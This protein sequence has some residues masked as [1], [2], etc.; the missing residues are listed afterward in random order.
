MT[1]TDRRRGRN[2][3]RLLR[4][5]DWRFLLSDPQPAKSICFADGLLAEAVTLISGNVVESHHSPPGDCDLAV[6][7]NPDPARLRAAWAALHPGGV[8]YSEWYSP[9]AGG[10]EGVRRRLEAAGFTDI[11]CYFPWPW[12]DRKSP[13]FWLPIEAP[14]AVHC[15]LTTRPRAPSMMLRAWSA[16]LQTLWHLGLRARLILPI[17]VTARKPGAVEAD[18]NLP[19]TIRAG[20][21]AWGLGLTPQRLSWLLLTGGQSN[22]NKVVSLVFADSDPQPRMIVKQA[23]VP[24]SIPALAR[25]AATLQVVQALRPGG[26]PGVPRVIFFRERAGQTMLGETVLKGQPLFTLLRPDNY[27][28]FAFKVTDWLADLAGYAPSCSRAD[29]RNRL[30]ET[31]LA[32]FEKS[33]GAILNPSQLVETRAI[34]STLDDVRLVCEHRDCSPWNV[35]VRADGELAF[36]DWESSEPCGLPALDLIYFLT[37]LAFFVDGAMESGRFRD[38][39]RA[40]LNPATFTGKVSAECQRQYVAR[41][42]LD[43]AALRPLRLLVWLIHSKSEYEQF[44]AEAAGQPEPAALRRSLFVSL[45]EEEL[46]YASGA[47]KT[48]A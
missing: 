13:L 40:A 26:M 22:I 23:R 27:R 7:V 9:R 21:S 48:G 28:D 31:A 45:W 34:L 30:I 42:G 3:N 5:A 1:I 16:L 24:E 38:S 39:Y 18:A 8:C 37:Y 10:P 6:A 47:V 12:P 11:T 43:P 20:W 35:L 19:D 46:H 41:T 44:V 14:E 29:W 4:R 36:L 33:F 17:C 15:F 32:D 2:H 25:E